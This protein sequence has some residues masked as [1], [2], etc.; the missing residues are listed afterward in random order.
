MC[1]D[2]QLERTVHP[3]GKTWQ[4]ELETGGHFMPMVRKEK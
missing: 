2:L 1:L 3:D 4:Q